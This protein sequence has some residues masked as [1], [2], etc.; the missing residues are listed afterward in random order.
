MKGALQGNPR[1][2]GQLGP[3][4]RTERLLDEITRQTNSL[5]ALDRLHYPMGLDIGGDNPESVAMA[6]LGEIQA[7]MNRRAGGS[8]KLRASAIHETY[9][10]EPSCSRKFSMAES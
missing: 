10:L 8:L 1:Y 6:V 2:I 7:V 9:Q 4:D 5:P 3:R